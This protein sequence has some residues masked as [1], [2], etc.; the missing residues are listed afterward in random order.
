MLTALAA[1]T[2]LGASQLFAAPNE[3]GTWTNTAGGVWSNADTGNWSGGI[4]A[5]G[6][7]F[8]AHFNTLDITAATTVSLGAP[9]TIGNL[10]FGDTANS[11][12]GRWVLDNNS[13]PANILTLSGATPTITVNNLG[14]GTLTNSTVTISAV[15]SGSNGLI[16]DGTGTVAG[17]SSF[18]KGVLVLSG[19]NNY[20]G[21]T[22]ISSG[23]LAAANS[24]AF[25]TGDVTVS[26]GAQLQVRGVNIA[27]TININGAN[28]LFSTSSS[29]SN[30]SGIV[31]LQSD[32]SISLATNSGN[33]TMTLSG[34][35]NLSGNTLSVNT[36]NVSPAVTISAV[37]NGSGGITKN[38]DGTLRISGDNINVGTYSGTTKV[39]R[40]VLELGSDGA[41]GS[42]TF[43]FAVSNNTTGHIRS[44]NTTAR[45]V[46]AAVAISGVGTDSVYRFGS[47]SAA[48]NGDLTF[49]NTTDIALDTIQRAFDVRNRTQFDAGFT[50]TGG[51][52]MQGGA[53]TLVIN[54]DSD[55]SGDTTVNVGTLL[56]NGTHTGGGAYTIAGSATLG[57]SGSIDSTVT[58]DGKLSPGNSIDTLTAGDTTFSAGSVFEVELGSGVSDLLAINGNLTLADGALLNL[59]GT[60]DGV[61]SYIIASYTGTLSGTFSNPTLPVGYSI[62]Y[63]SGSNSQISLLVP[64]PASLAMLGLAGLTILSARRRKA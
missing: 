5:D 49:T 55:Y 15:I 26:S 31:N 11:T 9:R 22:T 34:T 35:L 3:S 61:T 12:V 41:L 37:I 23:A 8:T 27:N 56:V 47:T 48:S 2:G 19:A 39:T 43:D 1:G 52:L 57:G 17:Q 32:S 21:G 45:T 6:A 14:N 33:A 38:N 18:G 59:L 24:S 42:G 51:I 54:G 62:D 40:G 10:V 16:K 46:A 20:S 64:E 30:L 63:G 28:A 29:G 7:G 25:G 58:V 36:I 50:G 53:G 44:S 13:T 4:V 60:A